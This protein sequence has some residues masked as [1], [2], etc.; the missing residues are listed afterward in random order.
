MVVG[1]GGGDE[2]D[3]G[4]RQPDE[5]A[6][7]DR[8]PAATGRRPELVKAMSRPMTV[9]DSAKMASCRSKPYQR[10]SPSLAVSVPTRAGS[11]RIVLIS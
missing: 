8:S 9:S 7:E 6:R 5:P 10:P 11:S 3:D 1:S 2:D 4:E